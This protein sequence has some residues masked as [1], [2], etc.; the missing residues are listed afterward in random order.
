M[1]LRK[2]FG[3]IDA[4]SI[5]A[6][7]NTGNEQGRGFIVRIQFEGSSRVCLGLIEMSLP[8]S[9]S[10]LVQL[11]LGANSVDDAAT[12]TSNDQQ[13]QDNRHPGLREFHFMYGSP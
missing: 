3:C 5:L 7:N 12:G 9:P 6:M 13:R 2:I 4:G 8:I 1:R 11:V 10:R